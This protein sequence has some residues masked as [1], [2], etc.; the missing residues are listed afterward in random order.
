MMN[1]VQD[2]ILLTVRTP[3]VLG[4]FVRIGTKIS[5]TKGGNL[6]SAVISVNCVWP[7]G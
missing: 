1:F 4:S 2:F 3:L 6:G 5:V 7:T